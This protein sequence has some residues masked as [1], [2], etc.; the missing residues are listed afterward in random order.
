MKDPTNPVAP[1]SR[2]CTPPI[3]LYV[4]GMRPIRALACLAALALAG[5]A[6]SDDGGLDPEAEAELLEDALLTDDDVPDGFEETDPSDEDDDTLEDCLEE[7][8][9]DPDA[10]DDS[11]VAETGP[12]AF[13]RASDT[14]FA[15]IE[16]ELRSV[17]PTG[18][19]EDVLEAMGDDDF[20]ACML[21]GFLAN[22]EAD[23]QTIEDPDLDEADVPVDADATG[24]LE[25]TGEISGLQFEGRILVALV[26]NHVVSL[27]LT[28]VNDELDDD[29]VED[30]FGTMI[31]RLDG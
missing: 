21:D 22:A 23:D 20:Q 7:V 15:G 27:E 30:L 16:A 25:F 31:D 19:V 3:L 28:S 9:L 8:D 12:A 13:E 29:E 24:G 5:G 6:C 10:L 4:A 14:G 2:T 17:D 26:G 18:P 1:V 11:T